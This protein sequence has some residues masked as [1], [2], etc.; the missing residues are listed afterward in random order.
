[1]YHLYVTTDIYRICQIFVARFTIW[2]GL[3]NALGRLS[4]QKPPRGAG[5]DYLRQRSYVLPGILFVFLY[6]C[7]SASL[8]RNFVKFGEGKTDSLEDLAFFLLV[9]SS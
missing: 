4:L 2:G 5:A 7:V 3:S 8:D 6:V 1:M 9:F